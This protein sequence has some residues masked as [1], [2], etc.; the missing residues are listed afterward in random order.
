MVC[1]EDEHVLSWFMVS[2]VYTKIYSKYYFKSKINRQTVRQTDRQ[3]L[4]LK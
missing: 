3:V 4:G 2:G 1:Y